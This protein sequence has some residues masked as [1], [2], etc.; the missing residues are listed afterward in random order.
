LTGESSQ[1]S[2]AYYRTLG[3]YLHYRERFWSVSFTEI[4][5][6]YWPRLK[7]YPSSY[8]HTLKSQAMQMKKVT[9]KGMIQGSSRTMHGI[10]MLESS[11]WGRKLS[12]TRPT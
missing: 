6:L 1:S 11:D 10:R 3:I 2:T 7:E 8:I 12:I 9:G 5:P 4:T